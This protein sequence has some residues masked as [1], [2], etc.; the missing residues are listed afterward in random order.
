MGVA[1]HGEDGQGPG[2]RWPGSGICYG[3]SALGRGVA[4]VEGRCMRVAL[5]RR[6]A[7]MEG[8]RRYDIE[9]QGGAVAPGIRRRAVGGASSGV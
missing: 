1:S 7:A 3:R 8:G 4:T 2:V 9:R 6:I 5:G